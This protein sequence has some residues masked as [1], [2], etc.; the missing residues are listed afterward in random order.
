MIGDVHQDQ[1]PH[2]ESRH[3]NNNEIDFLYGASTNQVF[4]VSATAQASTEKQIDMRKYE[5]APHY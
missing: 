3:S 2:L 1:N 5:G 4:E